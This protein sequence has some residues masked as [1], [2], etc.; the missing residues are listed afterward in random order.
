MP[1]AHLP[2]TALESCHRAGIQPSGWLTLA[3]QGGLRFASSLCSMLPTEVG[4]ADLIWRCISSSIAAAIS[5]HR[6]LYKRRARTVEDSGTQGRPLAL[7]RAQESDYRRG[8]AEVE[9]YF[10]NRFSKARRASSARAPPLVVSFSTVT[11]MAK[12]VQLLAASLRAMRSGTG[13]RHSKRLPG[14]K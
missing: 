5:S 6:S 11:F 13:C 4:R 8:T 14:S 10:L 1:A 3:W 2:Q 12:K 9:A 7:R